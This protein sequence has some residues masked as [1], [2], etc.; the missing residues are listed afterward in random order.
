MDSLVQMCLLLSPGE[1]KEDVQLDG[2][3]LLRGGCHRRER[4]PIFGFSVC[5]LY[6][7]PFEACQKSHEVEHFGFEQINEDWIL[8]DH[9]IFLL[10]EL[11]ASL[12]LAPV[13]S[14][15]LC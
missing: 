5:T 1:G 12:L 6:I 7:C 14:H 15:V 11:S 10:K 4:I 9:F 13:L 8:F 2:L 3:R